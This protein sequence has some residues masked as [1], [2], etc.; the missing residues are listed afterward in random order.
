[1]AIRFSSLNE[2]TFFTAAHPRR[3]WR[4]RY[5]WLATKQPFCANIATCCRRPGR[6]HLCLHLE[7]GLLRN[8]AHD[9]AS[10]PATLTASPAQ[11]ALQQSRLGSQWRPSSS[12]G[13]AS[14]S[15]TVSKRIG[16]CLC[17]LELA[18]TAAEAARTTVSILPTSKLSRPVPPLANLSSS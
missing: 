16:H 8:E 11:S 3:R 6:R 2:S 18:R 10:A 14:P 15:R 5:Y 13:P 7:S 1:M 4:S 12:N 17:P 9:D